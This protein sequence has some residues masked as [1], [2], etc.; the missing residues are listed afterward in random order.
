VTNAQLAAFAKRLAAGFEGNPGDSHVWQLLDAIKDA[1]PE[2][3]RV[4][5]KAGESGKAPKAVRLNTRAYKPKLLA[6]LYADWLFANWI[7]FNTRDGELDLVRMA[8][9]PLE[10][11]GRKRAPGRYSKDGMPTLHGWCIAQKERMESWGMPPLNVKTMRGLEKR[12]DKDAGFQRQVLGWLT[13]GHVLL[14][15]RKA[16]M[17]RLLA[18]TGE[19][20][21]SEWFVPPE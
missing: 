8:S 14:D 17:E 11:H 12:Y 20:G 6:L 10:M 16:D 9:S 7:A 1:A 19:D 18:Q 3:L 4:W 2:A 5:L 21:A 15:E 13:P